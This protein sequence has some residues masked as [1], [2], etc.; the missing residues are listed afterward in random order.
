MK[1]WFHSTY[2]QELDADDTFSYDTMTDSKLF[3]TLVSCSYDA[4]MIYQDELDI[5]T[6]RYKDARKRYRTARRALDILEANDVDVSDL[7]WTN[8]AQNAPDFRPPPE[9]F[10]YSLDVE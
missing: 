9:R 3:S 1:V 2:E 4:E 6:K 8:Y 10:I 7:F 5:T